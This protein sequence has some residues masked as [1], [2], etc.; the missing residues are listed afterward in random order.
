MSGERGMRKSNLKIAHD[1]RLPVKHVDS[2]EINLS[3]LE[4]FGIPDPLSA[5]HTLPHSAKINTTRPTK[6]KDNAHP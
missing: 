5:L 4:K 1:S 2:C 6:N 3:Q